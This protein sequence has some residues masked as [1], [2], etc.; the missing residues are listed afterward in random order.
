M[1]H[2]CWL[3]SPHSST[4]SFEPFLP[5]CIVQEEVT[6]KTRLAAK[7]EVCP[8]MSIYQALGYKDLNQVQ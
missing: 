4:Q 2:L 3:A 5:A 6:V 7:K 1:D 8:C